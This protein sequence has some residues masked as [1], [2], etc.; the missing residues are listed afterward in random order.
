MFSLLKLRISYLSYMWNCISTRLWA[1]GY[2]DGNSVN[3]V[4]CGLSHCLH[5]ADSGSNSSSVW[6]LLFSSLN[7]INS[8]DAKRSGVKSSGSEG[9]AP[10]NNSVIPVDYKSFKATWTEVVHINRERWRAKVPK[11]NVL[12]RKNLLL[13]LSRQTSYP[14]ANQ[15][16]AF[17]DLQAF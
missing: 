8:S 6:F 4:F 1:L 17:C 12:F 10:I 14:L 13:E 5:A 7:S 11:G 9:S 3:T 16:P 15:V 2:H